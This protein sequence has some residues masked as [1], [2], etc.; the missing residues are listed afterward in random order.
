MYNWAYNVY[1]T[2]YVSTVDLRTSKMK[3]RNTNCISIDEITHT[4]HS[5]YINLSYSM[6]SWAVA[7][8]YDMMFLTMASRPGIL[9]VAIAPPDRRIIVPNG[10]KD[11]TWCEEGIEAECL[12]LGWWM[13]WA[14]SVCHLHA[15][16]TS[17][18]STATGL[19]QFMF[20]SIRV[21]QRW[22][23]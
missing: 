8:W 23:V 1:R 3:Q 4:I 13:D 5:V 16:N 7:T 14:L 2:L 19:S 11:N 20:S 6:R 12:S 17:T 18:V 9:Q 22:F 21:V 15:A 10:D